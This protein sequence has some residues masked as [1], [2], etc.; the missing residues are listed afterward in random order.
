MRYSLCCG[1]LQSYFF[2]DNLTYFLCFVNNHEMFL[3]I[4]YKQLR[5]AAPIAILCTIAFIYTI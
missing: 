5:L 1:T 3:T 4:V 2:I